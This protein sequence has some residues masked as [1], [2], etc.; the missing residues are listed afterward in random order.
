MSKTSRASMWTLRTQRNILIFSLLPLPSLGVNTID[1]LVS[2]SGSEISTSRGDIYGQWSFS[3]RS[4]L[5]DLDVLP[6]VYLFLWGRNFTSRDRNKYVQ[7]IFLKFD[8]FVYSSTFIG[9][10]GSNSSHTPLKYICAKTQTKSNKNNLNSLL[11]GL[12]FGYECDWE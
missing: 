11:S 8:T 12:V 7:I 10:S 5:T 4:T 9:R 1:V 6:H 2:V 3:M